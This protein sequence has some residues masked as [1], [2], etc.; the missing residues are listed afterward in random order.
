MYTQT[1]FSA[2]VARHFEFLTSEYG[3]SP[4]PVQVSGKTAW[5]TY[6]SLAMKVIVEYE[7][8]GYCGVSVLNLRHVKA[9]PAERSEFDLEEIVAASG[10]RIQRRQ[11]PRSP[12]EA[13][14]RAAETLKTVGASVLKGDFEPL[15]IRQR[16]AVE[17]ARHHSPLAPD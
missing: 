8:G 17:A 1:E 4:Q 6:V 2:D 14:A 11:E 16:K 3:M 7:L 9:D 13:L 5:I 15:H 10:V 12:S